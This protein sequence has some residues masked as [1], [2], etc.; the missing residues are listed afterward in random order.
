MN[1]KKTKNILYLSFYYE[2]DLCAGSFRNTPLSKKLSSIEGN[3]IEVFT[4]I[5]NRYKTYEDKFV[6]SQGK[7]NLKV[8]RINVPLH[9]STVVGQAIT[10]SFFFFKTIFRTY[11][12]KYDLVFASSSRFFTAFLGYVIARNKNLKLYLDIRDIFFD[13][14]LNIY[15]K[16]KLFIF[17]FE[18]LFKRLESLV[19]NNA[20][21]INLISPGFESY[22]KKFKCK[23]LSYYTNGVDDKFVYN[24]CNKSITKKTLKSVVYAGN[25]GDGQGLDKILPK[26]AKKTQNTH[27]FKIYGDGGAKH[28]LVQQIELLEIKNIIIYKP[29]SRDKLIDIY[30]SADILFVHLNNLKAFEKVLPSKIFELAS[31]SKPIIAGLSGFSA[32]FIRNEVSHSYVFNPCDDVDMI[33][34]LNEIKNVKINRSDFIMKYKRSSIDSAFVKSIISYL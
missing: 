10:F 15:K 30:C 21:H 16:N 14:I 6:L 32:N 11:N 26:V 24:S 29:I 13:T 2:P 9:N 19:F 25:I 8:N 23:N 12:T 7:N 31:F 20:T 5:P 18:K 17:V 1:N 27:L 4:T 28:K 33:K 3:N 34:K 22:F